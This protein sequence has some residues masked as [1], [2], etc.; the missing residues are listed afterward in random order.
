VAPVEDAMKCER[1]SAD[2][3]RMRGLALPV[4]PLQ[5]RLLR[6]VMERLHSHIDTRSADFRANRDRM[7]ALVDEY[8]ARLEQVR[9]GGGAKYVARFAKNRRFVDRLGNSRYKQVVL[10]YARWS[11]DRRWLPGV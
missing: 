6:L 1:C 8:R 4:L 10:Q 9:Q 5:D 11:F 2:M 7:Q 3:Y